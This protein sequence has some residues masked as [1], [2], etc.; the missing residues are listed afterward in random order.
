MRKIVFLYTKV[1]KGARFADNKTLDV[2]TH[3]KP[4]ETFQ[5]YTHY[6]SSHPLSVEK[7][8]IKRDT[9]SVE[10]I[11]ELRKL[12]FLTR[13]LERGDPRQ[14]AENILAEINF[15]HETRR[16]KT[17]QIQKCFAFHREFQPSYA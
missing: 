4:A 11:F 12:E 2:R 8:F 10:E 16:H 7:G 5:Y 15:H 14:L 3:Y 6:S 17:K 9:N 1:F 13:L